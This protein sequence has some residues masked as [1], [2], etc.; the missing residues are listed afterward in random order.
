MSTVHLFVDTN[1]FIQCKKYDQIDWNIGELADANE[2]VVMVAR[3]V[4]SEIDRQK[5]GGNSRLAKRAR[6][7]NS[8]F[9]QMLADDSNQFVTEVRGKK[10]VF[11]F[12]PLYKLKELSDAVSE[13]DVMAQNDDALVATAKLYQQ[14][15][16][17]HNIHLLTQDNGMI[18]SA[19]LCGVPYVMP[20]DDWNLPPEKDEKDKRIAELEDKVRIFNQQFPVIEI[21]DQFVS[22]EQLVLLQELTDNIEDVLVA[23]V[24]DLH[25]MVQDFETQE[26]VS[27]PLDM[28]GL[29]RKDFV[30]PTE[31]AIAEYTSKYDQWL[32]DYSDWLHRVYEYLEHRKRVLTVG[33]TLE[34]SGIVPVKHLVIEITARGNIEIAPPSSGEDEEQNDIPEA[35]Q[36][37][38][39]PRGKWVSAFDRGFSGIGSLLAQPMFDP[40]RDRDFDFP[41]PHQRDRNGFYWK[42]GRPSDFSKE[43]ILECDE[44]RHRV[45]PRHFALALRSTTLDK[46]VG[47]ALEVLVTGE[48]LP[49]PCRLTIPVRLSHIEKDSYEVLQKVVEERYLRKDLL[50]KL[51][52]GLYTEHD[53]AARKLYDTEIRDDTTY[54]KVK[55]IFDAFFDVELDNRKRQIAPTC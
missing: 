5:Q 33:F 13:L 11:Q 54:G 4:Q 49:E 30:P 35:P 19:K 9:G 8:L 14:R 1:F 47:G 12:A 45:E 6:T 32:D 37:P 41:T 27:E 21:T 24:Q 55:R 31:K 7:A 23:Y 29:G 40:I 46:N 16:L 36:P 48:N 18:L 26:K 34:N 52:I 20:P 38:N 17:E 15:N 43:W 50:R 44:F 51:I 39:P 42:D 22:N 25:P 53:N 10:I 2:I 3:P 28:F